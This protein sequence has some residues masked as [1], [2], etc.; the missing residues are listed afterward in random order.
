MIVRFSLLLLI[1][2]SGLLVYGVDG[3]AGDY[4]SNSQ[5]L[6]ILF[7]NCPIILFGTYMTQHALPEAISSFKE[8]VDL[9]D[10]SFRKLS[11]RIEKISFSFI[12][13]LVIGIVYTLLLTDVSLDVQRTLVEGVTLHSLWG[14]FFVSFNN[15]LTSTGFWLGFSIWLTVFQISRQPLKVELSMGLIEKFRGLSMLNFWFSLFYFLAVSISFAVSVIG[16]P[17]VSLTE[18]LFSPL[19]VFIVIGVACVI[20]P[21][22]NIHRALIGLKKRELSEIEVEY[23]RLRIELDEA[24]RRVEGVEVGAFATMS[25]LFS[26]QI[27][28]R[29]LREAPEW[30]IDM[31]FVSKLASVVLIPA[32]VR[33]AVELFNRLYMR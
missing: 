9:D 16:A 11:D 4:L 10:D 29:R 15:I 5:L 28:E 21:F 32:V 20:I 18:V 13:C 14:L 22:Y 7:V 3:L 1:W 31:G 25:R 2:L 19:L 23:E 6:S 33:I 26:L 8:L 27:R 30:P 24:S 12:P 17:A